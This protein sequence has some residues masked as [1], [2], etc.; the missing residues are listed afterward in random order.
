ME[1]TDNGQ[2]PQVVT[3]DIAALEAAVNQAVSR[4]EEIYQLLPDFAPAKADGL[5]GMPA[6]TVSDEFLEACAFAA[7]KDPTMQAR[8]GLDPVRARLVIARNLRYD[9]LAAVAEA[10]A[11]DI[12]Y[13]MVRDRWDVAQQALQVYSIAKG[14]TR[15]ER[16]DAALAHVRKMKTALGRGRNRGKLKTA[17]GPLPVPPKQ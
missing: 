9:T 12:R 8:T 3:P 5:A 16:A 11:R 14:F 13:N 7:E 1:T 4:L 10:L 17:P 6:R 15:N 2:N